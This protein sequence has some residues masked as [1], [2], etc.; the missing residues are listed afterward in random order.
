M[1]GLFLI[2]ALF[3]FNLTYAQSVGIG[4]ASPDNSS[5]L[6]IN[7]TTKGVLVPRMNSTQIAAIVSP[8]AALMVYQTNGIP[9]FYY[10][11]GNAASPVWKRVGDEANFSGSSQAYYATTNTNFIVPAGVYRINFEMTGGGGGAGGTY[12]NGA[13]SYGGGGGG[14]GG[15]ASGY[16]IVTPG[17]SLTI[18]VGDRGVSG[19]SGTPGSNGTEGGLS[20][21]SSGLPV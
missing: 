9:G 10:N 4:T 19:A 13:S 15:Y 17:E 8:A 21:I 16:I 12:L 1:K 7:S 20:E 3:F 11:A 6:E 14:G 5:Q 18:A 2:N